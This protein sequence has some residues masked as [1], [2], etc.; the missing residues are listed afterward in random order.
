MRN[1][2]Q[3]E[4]NFNKVSWRKNLKM[5]FYIGVPALVAL[6]SAIFPVQP[7]LRQAMVG[8]ILVWFVVGSWLFAAPK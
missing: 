1:K 8:F 3:Q 7:F 2:I 6:S 4:M 5:I